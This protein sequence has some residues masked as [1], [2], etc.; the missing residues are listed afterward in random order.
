ME[1]FLFSTVL[2]EIVYEEW[3]WQQ[4]DERYEG[5]QS[6][7]CPD[8]SVSQLQLVRVEKRRVEA[9]LTEEGLGDDRGDQGADAVEEVQGIHVWRGVIARPSPDSDLEQITHRVEG[10]MTEAENELD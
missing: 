6:L 8:L 3:G 7:D 5:I 10:S 9:G 1:P 2:D 4:H